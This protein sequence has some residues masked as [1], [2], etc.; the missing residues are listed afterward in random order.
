V[1]RPPADWSDLIQTVGWGM[2]DCQ[3]QMWACAVWLPV[4]LVLDSG[5]TMLTLA[6]LCPTVGRRACDHNYVKER[7]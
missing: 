5:G 6:R 4:G 2:L 3:G 1:A 7:T